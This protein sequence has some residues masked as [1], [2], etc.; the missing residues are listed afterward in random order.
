MV[1]P[2]AHATVVTGSRAGYHL[3]ADRL[4]ERTALSDCSPFGPLS[5]SRS[6]DLAWVIT[7][8]EAFNCCPRHFTSEG[9]RKAVMMPQWQGSGKKRE[10]KTFDEAGANSSQ[11]LKLFRGGFKM[12]QGLIFLLL[13]ETA[14][15]H[16]CI[17]IRIDVLPNPEKETSL[18]SFI[19]RDLLPSS[20]DGYYRYTGS[21]TTPPCSKV[22]EW[23][24]FSRPVYLSHSQV[25]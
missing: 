24:I 8:A 2:A 14:A 10:K 5:A 11:A 23:I 4:S 22:V 21:L 15:F 13:H 20:V 12:L 1:I 6:R 3:T 16:F 7:R 25:C 17:L 18:R 19:L 9:V